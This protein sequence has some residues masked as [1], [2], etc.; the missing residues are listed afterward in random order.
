[1]YSERCAT[2]NCVRLL[3][4]SGV[5]TACPSSGTLDWDHDQAEQRL[6]AATQYLDFPT[7]WY[8]YLRDPL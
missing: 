6:I 3:N 4:H 1:M 5:C 2:P 7:P 8:H